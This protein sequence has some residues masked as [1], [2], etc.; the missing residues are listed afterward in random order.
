MSSLLQTVNLSFSYGRIE[1][2]RAVNVHLFSGEIVAL[3][4]PNGSGKSTLIKTL[5]GA[6]RGGG[7]IKWDERPIEQWRRRELA[8]HVAYLAQSPL[9]EPSQSVLEVLADGKVD[10]KPVQASPH[11]VHVESDAAGP[12]TRLR[13]HTTSLDEFTPELNKIAAAQGWVLREVT[14]RKQTLEEMFER[15]TSK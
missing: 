12:R 9:Y 15:I 14:P 13:I 7:E 3:I 5:I 2:L 8:K 4:G 10:V 1:A 11:V 6:L